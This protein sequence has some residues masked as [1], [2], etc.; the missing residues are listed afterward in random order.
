V[1]FTEETI[2][3]GSLFKVIGLFPRFFLTEW[4]QVEADKNFKYNL[5]V[6]DTFLNI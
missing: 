2:F 5:I 4:L 6:L 1:S 3:S